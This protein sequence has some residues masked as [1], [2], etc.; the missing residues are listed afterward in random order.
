MIL[1]SD[2]LETGVI[3]QMRT[4]LIFSPQLAQWLLNDGFKIVDIK[5]KRDYPN[6]TVFV[7]AIEDGFSDSI[8]E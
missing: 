1:K 7:F 2:M 6:E 5:P 3:Q 8:K 4:K